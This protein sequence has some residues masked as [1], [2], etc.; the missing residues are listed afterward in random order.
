MALDVVS[1]CSEQS[2]KAKEPIR[3]TAISDVDVW[4]LLEHNG[5]WE[6]DIAET[7]LPEGVG[8][9]LDGL[10]ARTP[11]SRKL[12]IR[13]DR[14]ARNLTFFVV[15]T[16]P[17]RA[18]FRFQASTY[19]S[20]MALNIDAVV[21]S[22]SAAAEPQGGTRASALYLVC[23]HGRRDACCA[24]KGGTFYRALE[25]TSHDGE[26]WQSSHQGGHRF[27]AT[28]LYLPHGIHYGRLEPADAAQLVET[29]A[30]GRIH[31]P[32]KYRGNST[33]SVPVQAAEAWLREALSE[34][35]F[36]AVRHLADG[37][38]DDERHFAEFRVAELVTHRL[39]L[40]ERQGKDRRLVSCGADGPTPFAY[41][42]VVR[43]E[44][45]G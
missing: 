36:G 13:R 27:A 40:A 4:F 14:P 43:H 17:E 34:H 25:G 23:T 6:A 45:R 30:R 33:L 18:V 21:A 22:G 28:M 10:C 11:R 38:L 41:Y 37:E 29:H 15:L 2:L 24:R 44:A 26:L 9:F 16:R 5:R 7:E 31:D 39:V 12:L 42:D 3:G 1:T 32:A 35:R 20:L 19:E 8:A